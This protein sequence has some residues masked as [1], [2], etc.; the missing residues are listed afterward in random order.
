VATA[1]TLGVGVAGGSNRRPRRCEAVGE[2][3]AEGLDDEL[4]TLGGVIAGSGVEVA[5]GVCAAIGVEAVHA[6]TAW[7]KK[8]FFTAMVR[9]FSRLIIQGVAVGVG[10]GEVFCE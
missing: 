10:A 9:P 3:G 4:T 7:T 5:I 1:L 8:N 2:A 6:I